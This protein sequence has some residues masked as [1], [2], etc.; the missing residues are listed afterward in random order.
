MKKII[1][2]VVATLIALLAP[3]A[4][5]RGVQIQ[6]YDWNADLWVV[7]GG[8]YDSI[9][10]VSL[11]VRYTG[12][13]QAQWF[14]E[15]AGNGWFVVRNRFAGRLLTVNMSSATVVTHPRYEGPGF[16]WEQL[17]RIDDKRLRNAGGS[18][19]KTVYANGTQSLG[20]GSC[21]ITGTATWSF[22]PS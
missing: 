18:C 13:R 7:A 8:A 12:S 17:W 22:S 11:P 4:D 10:W 15:P 21:G 19:L 14:L 6:L 20:L 9:A 2:T 1:T 16:S 5:A 3:R